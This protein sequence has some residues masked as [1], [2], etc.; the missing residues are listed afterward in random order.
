MQN[1]V[2]TGISIAALSVKQYSL[3][4]ISSGLVEGTAVGTHNG[5]LAVA[6]EQSPTKRLGGKQ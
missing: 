5:A 6:R 3:C 2:G 1:D 4:V